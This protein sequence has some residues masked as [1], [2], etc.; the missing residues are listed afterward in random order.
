MVSK[1]QWCLI[2]LVLNMGVGVGTCCAI[3]GNELGPAER[4]RLERILTLMMNRGDDSR[5]C[6]LRC[7]K[8]LVSL[9]QRVSSWDIDNLLSRNFLS[10][11]PGVLNADYQDLTKPL[12]NILEELPHVRDLRPLNKDELLELDTMGL[13]LE[14]WGSAIGIRNG[15]HNNEVSHQKSFH[16]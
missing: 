4:I 9:E 16:K 8:Q 5:D 11:I 15:P 14:L 7:I 10:G 6:A 3:V 2:E 13:F 1:K 12:Q